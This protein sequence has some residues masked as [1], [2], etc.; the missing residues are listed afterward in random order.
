M[1]SIIGLNRKYINS[2]V[3]IC[4]FLIENAHHSAVLSL[5][6]NVGNLDL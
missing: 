4:V 5:I 3:N 6:I 2:I 1:L